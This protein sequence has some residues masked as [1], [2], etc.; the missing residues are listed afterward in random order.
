MYN[1][2]ILDKME[3]IILKYI[4]WLAGI[5]IGAA[6]WLINLEWRIRDNNTDIN[7]MEKKIS[8]LEKS[9][10]L[11]KQVCKDIEVIKTKISYLEDRT[12]GDNS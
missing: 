10:K 8:D 3:E 2:H 5:A 11:F 6:G 1:I 12:K 4:D 9:H 7:D